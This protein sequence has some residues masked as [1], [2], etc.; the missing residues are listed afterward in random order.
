MERPDVEKITGLSPVIAIEQKTTNKN[1]RSTVGTITEIGDFLRLLF[2]RASVAYSPNT[3][4]EMVHYSD[5]QIIDLILQDYS[6]KKIAILA[7]LVKGRKGHYRELFESLQ[8]KGYTIARVDGEIIE[9]HGNIRLDRYKIHDVELVVD[10]LIARE[11]NRQRLASS[12][13]DAMKQGKGTIMLYDFQVD[14]ARYFSRHL[15]CPTTGVSFNEPAPHSFS[16]NSPH[17]ACP[18]CNGLGFE[19]VYDVERIIPDSEKSIAQGGILPLGK[20]QTPYLKAQLEALA[21][22][23]DFSL[24]DP[25]KSISEEA[26]K[27]IVY[28]DSEPLRVENKISGL[29]NNYYMVRWE[30]IE[31]FIE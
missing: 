9:I 25:V 31:E 21:A 24:T 8:K 23:Y 20:N 22:R 4:E 11:E 12:L 2:A 18:R 28:G 16:F 27:A 3:G 7:P 15:M 14:R 5:N 10:R 29:S 17:G 30:G 6:Q 19:A 1:P 26:M 13:K